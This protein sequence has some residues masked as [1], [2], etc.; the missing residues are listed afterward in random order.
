MELAFPDS[1]APQLDVMWF[2][3]EEDTKEYFRK[4]TLNDLDV[5][6]QRTVWVNGEAL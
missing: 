6:R 2:L 3:N 5:E 1:I 4:L